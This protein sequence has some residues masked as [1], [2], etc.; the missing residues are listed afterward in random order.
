[1]NEKEKNELYK[2]FGIHDPGDV[3]E[4]EQDKEHLS[5]EILERIQATKEIQQR[6]QHSLKLKRKKTMLTMAAAIGFILISTGLLFF[7]P[8]NDDN[9]LTVTVPKGETRQLVLPDGST[10]WLNSASTFKYPKK[11]GKKRMVYLLDG[12][13]FFD[14]VHDDKVPFVVEASGIKTNVL[15]T[16]F[17]VKSYQALSTMSVAVVTGKVAVSDDQNQT[18]VLEKNEEV[19]YNKDHR[20]PT[21]LKVK[22]ME[23]KAW[24]NGNV[25][26][27]AAY[28]E[29]LVLAVENAYQV[30]IKYDQQKFKNCQN[31]IRFN[32]KQSLRE[33]LDLIKLIQGITYQIKEEK[34]VLITG[35][36]CN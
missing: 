4:N 24:N 31:S 22:A 29:D 17:V 16:S 36:G 30:K 13:G 32:T 25:I 21:V 26:L 27:N 19:V 18:S 5:Q 1:M 34:E 6:Q 7:H 28:F 9:Y 20:K 33:V 10:V 3:F 12:E 15:G 14:I 2:K 35:S 8:F 11:F 23:R